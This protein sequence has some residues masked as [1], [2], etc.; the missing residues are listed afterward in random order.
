MECR[1]FVSGRT[2]TPLE[3]LQ[4][5]NSYYRMVVENATDMLSKHDPDGICKYASP[6]FRHLLGYKPEEMIGRNA[7]E[8]LHPDDLENIRKSY[9]G[10]LGR[11]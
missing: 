10:G 9:R 8:F 4:N 1:F 3:A 6:S 2:L 11:K 5:E 7:V